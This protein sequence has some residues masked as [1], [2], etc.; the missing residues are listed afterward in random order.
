MKSKDIAALIAYRM[1]RAEDS[2]KAAK[3]MYDKNMLSFAMNRIYYTF[4]SRILIRN[5]LY[6][7]HL[8]EPTEIRSQ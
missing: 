5:S 6:S 3:I 7:V 1:Q 2:L 4:R 8:T